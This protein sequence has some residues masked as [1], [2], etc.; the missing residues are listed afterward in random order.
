MALAKKGQIGAV[1]LVIV[2]PRG[3]M[4]L[5]YAGAFEAHTIVGCNELARRLT[6]SMFEKK[7]PIITPR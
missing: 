4:Q 1:A 5:G 6:A 3:Q 2:N 7:S